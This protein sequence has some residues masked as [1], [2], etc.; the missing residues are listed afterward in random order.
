MRRE[1]I[2]PRE[3]VGTLARELDRMHATSGF[4]DCHSMGELTAMHISLMLDVKP[5]A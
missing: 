4:G 3:H 5:I 1:D 2:A